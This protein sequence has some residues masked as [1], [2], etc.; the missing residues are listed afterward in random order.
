MHI[1]LYFGVLILSSFG[2]VSDQI[3][4]LIYTNKKTDLN[5]NVHVIDTKYVSV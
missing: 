5:S 3:E 2:G 1:V 4:S